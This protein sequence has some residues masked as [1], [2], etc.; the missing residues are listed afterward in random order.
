MVKTGE[1][2]YISPTAAPPVAH[3]RLVLVAFG[4][5]AAL[6]LYCL[7]YL[8]SQSLPWPIRKGMHQQDR[9]GGYATRIDSWRVL[10]ERQT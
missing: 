5:L 8:S 9:L 1:S 10:K 6:A 2:K 3:P 4:R 7:L